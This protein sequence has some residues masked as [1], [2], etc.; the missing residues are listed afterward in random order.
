MITKDALIAAIPEC[1]SSKLDLVELCKE[2]SRVFAIKK[3]E[4][5]DLSNQKRRAAFISQCA[6]ESGHFKILT[7]NLNYS[8]EGLMKTFPSR[9]LNVQIAEGFARNPEKIANQVYSNRMGNGAPETGDGWKYRGRGIIQLTGKNNYAGFTKDMGI[10][11]ISN[12]DYLTTVAGAVESAYWFWTKNP[13]INAAAD[14]E[15]VAAVTKIIN[16]GSH[17]LQNRIDLYNRVLVALN[18]VN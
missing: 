5:T 3:N 11:V 14:K 4:A 13:K 12:P 6:H 17:G 9:F 15:D 1:K 10:D 16:G 18:K 8:A 2:I 7:E